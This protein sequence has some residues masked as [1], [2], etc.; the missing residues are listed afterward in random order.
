MRQSD[1]EELCK[2]LLREHF[3][4]YHA[5]SPSITFLT[6]KKIVTDFF[7]PQSLVNCL[8][9]SPVPYYSDETVSVPIH[10]V[11]GDICKVLGI[12]YERVD[13]PSLPFKMIIKPKEKA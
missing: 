4:Y 9:L 1:V 5:S 3:K 13:E 10:R 6:G 11:I 2:D 8:N 12:G 7:G